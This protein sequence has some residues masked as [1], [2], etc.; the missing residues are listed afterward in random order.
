M[1]SGLEAKLVSLKIKGPFSATHRD[2]FVI[3][4]S[5]SGKVLLPSHFEI[6]ADADNMIARIYAAIP[7]ADWTKS[8]NELITI[9]NLQVR[10][11]K[12]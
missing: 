6:Q 7:E 3:V 5:A 12:S 2:V 8:I 4:H 10:L 1:N 9:P 11:L